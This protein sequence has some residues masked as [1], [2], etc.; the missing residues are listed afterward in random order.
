MATA[1]RVKPL[2]QAGYDTVLFWS[3]MPGCPGTR[4]RCGHQVRRG[5]HDREIGRGCCFI[6]RADRK[7]GRAIGMARRPLCSVRAYRGQLRIENCENSPSRPRRDMAARR[8]LASIN[9]ATSC[10]RAFTRVV[11][12]MIAANHIPI[13]IVSYRNPDVRECEMNRSVLSPLFR[14]ISADSGHGQTILLQA[15]RLQ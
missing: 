7:P 15:R 11:R 6:G 1:L 2:P 9:L 12:L 13:I 8:M 3:P 4:K 5:W 14:L 10:C